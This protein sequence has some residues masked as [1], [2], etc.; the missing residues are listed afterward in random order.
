MK[1]SFTLFALLFAAV[2]IFANVQVSGIV[3]DDKGEPVVGASVQAIGTSIGTITDYDGQFELSVPD[4]V[5]TLQVSFIGMQAQEVPVQKNMRITLSESSEM[6]QEVVKTG[7]MN[8]SKGSFAGSAQA[9]NADNIEKKNPSEISKALAG[10][11]AGVQ[12]VNSS[13]QPGSNASIRV[14]GLGSI[15]ASSSPLYIVDGV[16]YG[17]DISSIDPGDI[18]STTILKDAT[19]TSLYGSRGA[20]GVILITTKKGTSGEQGKIDVDLKMGANMRLLPMYDVITDPAE[21]V[22]LSWQSIYNKLYTSAS[23]PTSVATL[24]SKQLFGSQGLPQAYN[25]WGVSGSELIDVNGHF[26]DDATR[27]AILPKYKNM[28]TDTWKKNIFRVGLK[29]EANVKI[30]GGTEKTTYF[31]SFGYLKDEGY[32]IS[33]DFSRFNV[34]SNLEYQ[35]KKWLKAGLNLA[36]AYS[37]YNSPGQSSNMNN[38]FAYVNG[39]PPIYPVFLYNDD[40]TRQLDPRTGI[41]AYDY[42]NTKNGK[43]G[44]GPGIN[45]AGSLLFDKQITTSHQFTG[46]AD[47][48]IKFYKDLKFTATIGYQYLGESGSQL[49]NSYYGDAAGIGRIYKSQTNIMVLTGNQ[50]FHYNKSIGDHTISAMA[51]HESNLV[52]QSQMYGQKNQIADPAGLEW[53]N[54][55]QNGYMSSATASQAIDSYLANVSYTYNERYLLTA[56]YRADGSS[57]FAKGHRW[58][59]F[60]SVG[61]AWNFTNEDFVSQNVSWLKNGKLRLSWGMLGNQGVSSNLYSDQYQIRYVGGDIGYTW[62][63]RGSEDLTWER[64]SQVDLGLEFTATKYLDVELDYFHKLIDHMLF[65]RY[66]APSI[67]Y[68]YEYINGGKMQTQG[69]EFSFKIHAVDMRNIKL[70]IRLNGSHIGNKLLELPKSLATDEDASEENSDWSN[71]MAPGHSLYEYNTAFYMGVNDK[72]QATYKAWYDADLGSLGSGKAEDMLQKGTTGNNHIDNVYLYKKN[73]P[74]ANIVETVTEIGSYAGHDF[75]GKKAE[76]I[77]DGGFGFDLEVYGVT[78]S[79]TCS[80]RIGGY[81]YDGQYATLMSSDKVGTHNW[82]KDIRNAWTV[83]TA[84]DVAAMPIEKQVPRLSNG[85]DL[86]ANMGSTRFLISN[87]FLAL[88]NIRIGYTFPKKLIEKIKLNT[89]QVW[90]AGD[91]LAIASARKG[92]NPM[93]SF[94]GSSSEYRYTP[95][96]TVM[97][98]IKFQF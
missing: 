8:V 55:V 12:V 57:K 46:N 67:G 85:A 75:T 32:Y 51:G 97:G 23:D 91:N 53:G 28:T 36:Y 60:G 27:E 52:V 31:T 13:G 29:A 80:Y 76:P 4:N 84:T 42:G 70:D 50:M 21:Y 63:F 79:A 65:P 77:I 6:L 25:L 72:G 19:A 45:P 41:D 71:N 61:A 2:S 18:A 14:R 38:G 37:S 64:Q 15:Y 44:F 73:H 68:T 62:Y 87:S 98:G 47:F 48:E 56:N 26:F 35:P 58:G 74:N 7:Y 82:H 83:A 54:A 10:E 34:R 95:L 81:G 1:K 66:V 5:K 11:V 96:S 3:V 93:T 30:H 94:A 33:S 92:Y 59:H 89:L 86:Y 88:N 39:I 78:L 9:V 69:V 20:N 24:A 16:T 17:G 90:V 22:E 43:R 40:G 49:T